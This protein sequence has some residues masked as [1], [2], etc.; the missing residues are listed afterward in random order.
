M[1]DPYRM[2]SF[3]V[4][5]TIFHEEMTWLHDNKWAVMEKYPDFLSLLSLGQFSHF[6]MCKIRDQMLIEA[7]EKA[8]LEEEKNRKV[9]DSSSLTGGYDR[10]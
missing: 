6:H 9:R 4:C 7:K 10:Q 1:S 5:K 3:E 2:I 8:G